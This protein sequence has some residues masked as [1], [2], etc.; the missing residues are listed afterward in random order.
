M[1]EAVGEFSPVSPFMAEVYRLSTFLP[2]Q[3]LCF[4]PTLSNDL[5]KLRASQGFS[6]LE[7][8][9]RQPQSF[10]PI[11]GSQTLATI[12]ESFPLHS[13]S[14]SLNPNLL[15]TLF[16]LLQ[17]LVSLLLPFSLN[18]SKKKSCGRPTSA[19][20][21]NPLSFAMNSSPPAL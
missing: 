21:Q 13:L 11:S 16:T 1:G 8:C 6:S 3:L 19:P 18:P 7:V 15:K 17:L 14:H 12:Q 2:T 9:I 10:A 20:T 4:L 5:E